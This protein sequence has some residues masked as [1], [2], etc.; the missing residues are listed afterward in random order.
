MRICLLCHKPAMFA[1]PSRPARRGAVRRGTIEVHLPLLDAGASGYILKDTS[2]ICLLHAIETVYGGGDYLSS[3]ALK[4]VIKRYV[5][6][7][8]STAGA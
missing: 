4:K 1:P 5:K 6:G 7:A 2:R 8:K 3:P